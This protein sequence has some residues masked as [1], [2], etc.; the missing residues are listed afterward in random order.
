MRPRPLVDLQTPAAPDV[1]LARFRDCLS[2]G[3]CGVEGHVGSKELSLALQGEARHVF[4]PWVSLEV[5]PWQGGARLRGV[6]G[7]HPNLWTLFVFIY[8]TWTV[9]FTAGVIYGYGQWITQESPWA[10]WV[11]LGAALA[12]GASCTVD[13]VGRAYGRRQMDTIRA[14]LRDQIP[15]AADVPPDAPPPWVPGG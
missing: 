10:L 7:P 15:D 2:T 5:Y 6:F 14:F 11:A 4:S 9:A 12:Q 3:K 1:V 8:A 13:L